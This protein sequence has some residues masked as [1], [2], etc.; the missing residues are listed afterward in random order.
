MAR[1]SFLK[2]NSIHVRIPYETLRRNKGVGSRGIER[3]DGE[4]WEGRKYKVQ[5]AW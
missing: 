1:P 4:W 5:Y 3:N 2:K